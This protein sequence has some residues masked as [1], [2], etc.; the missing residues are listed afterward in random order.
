MTDPHTSCLHTPC[1]FVTSSRS[2]SLEYDKDNTAC[3]HTHTPDKFLIHYLDYS[4]NTKKLLNVQVWKTAFFH[5]ISFSQ[6]KNLSA[7][8]SEI[9]GVLWWHAAQARTCTLH[10]RSVIQTCRSPTSHNQ[11]QVLRN[12]RGKVAVTNSSGFPRQTGFFSM[13]NS[14]HTQNILVRKE[15]LPKIYYL[16]DE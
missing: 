6:I 1:G 12:Q 7:H 11:F 16:S 9:C 13:P 5:S 3:T 15:T 10:V 14:I 8:T 2:N 4:N